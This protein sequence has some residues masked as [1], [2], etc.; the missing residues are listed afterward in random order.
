MKNEKM[1]N[2]NING[3][4]FDSISPN[5]TRLRRTDN[6]ERRFTMFDNIELVFRLQ[7]TFYNDIQRSTQV[8]EERFTCGLWSNI[9][10]QYNIWRGTERD[11]NRIIPIQLD[12]WR[13]CKT[14]NKGGQ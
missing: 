3:F 10:M 4:D 1:D 13:Q 11:R 7:P 2:I 9:E 5:H 8:V 12:H 6:N 14:D